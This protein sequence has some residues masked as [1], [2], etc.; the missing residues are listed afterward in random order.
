M[1]FDIHISQTVVECNS[2]TI[3]T[4]VNLDRSM[5]NK[6]KRYIA[7]LN[8][9]SQSYEASLAIWDHLPPD[10]SEHTPPNPSQTGWY[11]IYLP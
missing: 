5:R 9:S 7:L 11:S 3:M 4:I 2:E 1:Q 6:F 8:K 10:T